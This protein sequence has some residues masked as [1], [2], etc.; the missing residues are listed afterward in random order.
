MPPNRVPPQTQSGSPLSVD[1]GTEFRLKNSK[2]LEGIKRFAWS[3]D[4]SKIAAP[5]HD[6][7][8]RLWDVATRAQTE[9]R[10]HEGVVTSV[11]WT[12][13]GQTLASGSD[14]MTVRLWTVKERKEARRPLEGHT[15]P[16]TGVAFSDNLLA[17][18]S[19]DKTI[20][21]WRTS[22]YEEQTCVAHD[23]KVLGIAWSPDGETLASA[24]F[25]TRM[26]LWT[27]DRGLQLRLGHTGQ[28]FCV[29]W[30]SDGDSLVSG[31]QDGEIIIWDKTGRIRCRFKG[32]ETDVF[33]LSLSK[34]S[35][36]LVSKSEEDSCIWNY[37]ALNI[38]NPG[39][40][41]DQGN[42]LAAL[43]VRLKLR[44]KT[45]YST[46]AFHPKIP[47]RLAAS[48]GRFDDVVSVFDLRLDEFA[49]R[50]RNAGKVFVVHGH[51]DLE[52]K[53]SNLLREAGLSP[54]IL[55]READG[56]LTTIEKFERHADVG[57]AVVI[58][59]PDDAGKLKDK[60]ELRPRARQNVVFELGYFVGKL[61]RGRVIALVS[62]KD[63]EIPSDYRGVL[64]I[65]IRNDDA[66]RLRL[67]R[68]LKEAGAD[69]DLNGI[70]F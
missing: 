43:I 5:C 56:G 23:D 67:A 13:D 50:S 47:L 2:M 66:W 32:H 39:G 57:F 48:S 7:I 31:G 38:V 24:S 14:D 59:T 21:F 65:P 34:D 8:I 36:L 55:R 12:A 33:S 40:K 25:D 68:E 44:G 46:A 22:D 17:T 28:A 61:D 42:A 54:V 20:R 51:G 27:Q 35:R 26:G 41:D 6:G 30:S 10:G 60:P 49:E 64:F 11:S 9:L 70:K 16:I 45:P 29:A 58:L 69:V 15:A 62:D 1:L 18:A 52:D 63:L 19:D 4:G 37:S 53:V 3:P